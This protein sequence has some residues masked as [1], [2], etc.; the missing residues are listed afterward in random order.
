MDKSYWKYNPPP[1]N[2]QEYINNSI[3]YPIALSLYKKGVE[4]NK[5]IMLS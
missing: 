1:L 3:S 4:P 5:S 2:I